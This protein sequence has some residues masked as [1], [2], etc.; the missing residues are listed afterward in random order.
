MS[1]LDIF[2]Q[3]V[4]LLKN[5]NNAIAELNKLLHQVIISIIKQE[6]QIPDIIDDQKILEDKV[7]SVFTLIS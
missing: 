4:N 3:I 1:N 5:D 6:L 2:Q 7:Q